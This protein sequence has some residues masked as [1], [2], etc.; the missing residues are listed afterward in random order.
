LTA[1]ALE[2][3]HGPGRE[4]RI[5][6]YAARALTCPFANSVKRAPVSAILDLDTIQRESLE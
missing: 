1:E 5:R 3:D 6:T 4:A 2:P